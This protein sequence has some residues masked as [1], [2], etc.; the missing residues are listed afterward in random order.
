V[1]ISTDSFDVA[2][3]RKLSRLTVQSLDQDFLKKLADVV[4]PTQPQTLKKPIV[5]NKYNTQKHEV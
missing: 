2:T 4:V 1:Q 5:A 3:Q